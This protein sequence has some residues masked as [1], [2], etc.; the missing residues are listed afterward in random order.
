[1]RLRSVRLALLLLVVSGSLAA[2]IV[3]PVP[4]HRRAYEAPA[5][6]PLYGPPAPP[7]CRWVWVGRWECR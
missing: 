2:C 3:V 1:M 6:A 5:P 4:W 7:P